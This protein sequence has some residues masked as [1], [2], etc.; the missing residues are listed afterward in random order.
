MTEDLHKANKSIG[1]VSRNECPCPHDVKEAA[2]KGLVH[3]WISAV[4]FKRD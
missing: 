3:F 2:Y 4:F 1:F